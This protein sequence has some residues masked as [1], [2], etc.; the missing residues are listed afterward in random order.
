MRVLAVLIPVFAAGLAGFFV[1]TAQRGADSQFVQQQRNPLPLRPGDVEEAV[2]RAPGPSQERGSEAR[3]RSRGRDE[4]RNPWRCRVVY[5]SGLV[6]D[7]RV[8]V[9]PDGVYIGTHVGGTGVIEG[10]CV[11]VPR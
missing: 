7:Y 9:R 1:A 11:D 3:C 4:L 5:P 6:A 8:T 2:R 10:C